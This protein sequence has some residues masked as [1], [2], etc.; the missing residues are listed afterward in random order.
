VI[1][2]LNICHRFH[3]NC[4]VLFLLLDDVSSGIQVERVSEGYKI[5]CTVSYFGLHTPEIRWF[6]AGNAIDRAARN[7]FLMEAS[8]RKVLSSEISTPE[9]S[10]SPSECQISIPLYR[11][12]EISSVYMIKFPIHQSQIA[13]G[14]CR[15][16]H[17]ID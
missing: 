2:L 3:S 13:Y 6:S 8:H 15:P 17:V 16:N 11:C 4:T 7:W 5:N 10:D 9:Q 14:E 12:E 1:F